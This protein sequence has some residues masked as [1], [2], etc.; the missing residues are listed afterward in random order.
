MKIYVQ[1]KRIF[2]E[3]DIREAVNQLRYIFSEGDFFDLN[4]SE[5]R[6]WVKD[7]TIYG[8]LRPFK[9]V[10]TETE[11]LL[12]DGFIR[13]LNGSNG[14]CAGNTKEEAIAQGLCEL[15]ERISLKAIFTQEGMDFPT[16]DRDA[17]RNLSSFRIIQRIEE[18]GF[19]CYVKD[20]SLGGKL[21]VVGLILFD[22]ATSKYSFSIGS[23]LDF[24]IAIQRCITELFQ[25]RELNFAFSLQM[26]NT[27][28]D[29]AFEE[30]NSENAFHR[31]V[32]CCV[33]GQG[34]LPASFFTNSSYIRS[35]SPF[36]SGLTNK[37]AM[38]NALDIAIMNRYRVFVQDNSF[39]GFPAFR[40]FIADSPSFYSSLSQLIFAS[41]MRACFLE[42]MSFYYDFTSVKQP[43]FEAF[44]ESLA[45]I[46]SNQFSRNFGFS[47]FSQLGLIITNTDDADT[48]LLEICLYVRVKA[49]DKALEAYHR[50]FSS[51]LHYRAILF[52]LSKIINGDSFDMVL[53]SVVPNF[54]E[55]DD[56][57][58]EFYS[59]VRGLTK[60]PICPNCDSC[61]LK[62]HCRVDEWR[63]MSTVIS[64]LR[65]VWIK[66]SLH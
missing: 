20:C 36:K 58:E 46:N 27:L 25:G 53:K 49:F 40:V 42:C 33:N 5:L 50:Y 6:R 54:F 28:C 55:N 23:D 62:E 43:K 1:Q 18:L 11:V 59:I 13:N 66:R 32:K 63:D 60:L 38:E 45:F 22:S 3:S 39:L 65:S 57:F 10:V 19:D 7:N 30:K 15:Y 29:E 35:A 47:L 16:Y 12:P 31:Y 34:Q 48:R 24:D 26:F 37:Y 2:D 51:N 52:F 17:Y 14:L 8:I 64:K 21:P 4:E 9:D 41:D 56:R 44:A 61:A